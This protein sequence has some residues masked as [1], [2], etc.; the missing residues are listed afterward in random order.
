M[1][2]ESVGN[3]LQLLALGLEL[4][5][6]LLAGIEL[7]YPKLAKAI[8]DHAKGVNLQGASI[9]GPSAHDRWLTM[10][11]RD[12]LRG[13]FLEEKHRKGSRWVP[14]IL[15]WTVFSLF[16]IVRSFMFGD[17]ILV[18]ENTTFLLV[19]YLGVPAVIAIGSPTLIYLAA[20]VVR[21]TR[22][23]AE[24]RGLGSIGLVI[25]GVGLALE[26]YQVV[27][28]A[29]SDQPS[30]SQTP[31]A[32]QVLVSTIGLLLLIFLLYLVVVIKVEARLDQAEQNTTNH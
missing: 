13:D 32:L 27:T 7:R 6:L 28:V 18:A 30:I 24:D 23:F 31:Y 1:F 26:A 3:L 12:L 5:G 9:P 10:S 2:S 8:M 19:L 29:L 21:F 25:A 20:R 16:L 22:S 14:L 11:Y 4:T 15:L 17:H